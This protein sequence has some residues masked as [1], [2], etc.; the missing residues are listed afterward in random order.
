MCYLEAEMVSSAAQSS[1]RC[2][3]VVVRLTSY[4]LVFVLQGLIALKS[5]ASAQGAVAQT[6]A[7][8][9]VDTAA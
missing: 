7:G 1:R 3:V 2:L 6:P 9:L 8:A 5:W 4:L